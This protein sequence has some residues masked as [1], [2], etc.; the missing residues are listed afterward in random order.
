MV[1]LR[2][3]YAE[4]RTNCWIN[5]LR[6]GLMVAEVLRPLSFLAGRRDWSLEGVSPSARPSAEASDAT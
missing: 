5:L 2:S 3:E 1:M 6:C 4:V